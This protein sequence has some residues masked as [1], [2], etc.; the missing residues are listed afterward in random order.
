[1][2]ATATRTPAVPAELVEAR[3]TRWRQTP[4]TRIADS[5]AAAQ[6][7]DTVGV[8]TLYPVSSEIPNLY[9]A[10]MGDP[11]AATD[12]GHDSPSG[13]VY[14]WRWELGGR[15]AA[16]YT[17]IVRKRPTWIS[18]NLLPP[19][20]RLFAERR[21]PDELYDFGV[22][23][24]DAYRLVQALDRSYSPL[25]TAELRQEAEF[26]TGREHR[27]AYLKAVEELETR[28][29]LAKVFIGDDLEM[30]HAL[31]SNLYRKE[32]EAAERLLFEEALN[33]FLI[34]YL[35]HAVYASPFV[36]ARH[37]KLP[38][39]RLLPALE[40][41]VRGGKAHRLDH[42]DEKLQLYAWN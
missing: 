32:S 39:D 28:I 15:K 33:R 3:V 42:T 20:L 13:H 9:H 8:A 30:G 21:T 40:Y 24:K 41:L 35:A 12:S 27:A 17:S 5:E 11:T 38:E 34:T 4:N 37:L 23:S 10:Y 36:L 6:F 7:I 25:T 22:I 2:S 16:F 29:L 14:T 19:I 31:V 1:M 26:P 18:W